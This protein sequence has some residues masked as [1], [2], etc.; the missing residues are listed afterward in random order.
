[1]KL[2]PGNTGFKP[3][4]H[5]RSREVWGKENWEEKYKE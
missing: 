3:Q 4:T 1:M 5:L 2:N